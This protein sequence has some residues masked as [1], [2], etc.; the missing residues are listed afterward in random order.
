M[1]VEEVTDWVNKIQDLIRSQ[2]A[3][4]ERLKRYELEYN[5]REWDEAILY[6]NLFKVTEMVRELSSVLWT[7]WKVHEPW[8]LDVLKIDAKALIDKANSL[9]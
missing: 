4:I 5:K 9:T 6:N 2:D 3:E 8:P 7:I 1:T